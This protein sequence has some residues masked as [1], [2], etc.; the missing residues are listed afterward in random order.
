[1]LIAV[2][3]IKGQISGDKADTSLQVHILSATEE[4]L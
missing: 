3:V 4:R 1:M 2:C